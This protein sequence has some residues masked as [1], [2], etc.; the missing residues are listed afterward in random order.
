MLSMT[1]FSASRTLPATPS[2]FALPT[3]CIAVA[4]SIEETSTSPLS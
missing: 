4:G 2:S 3:L 1:R